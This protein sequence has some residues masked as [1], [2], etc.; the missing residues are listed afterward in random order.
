M[1]LSH[2]LRRLDGEALRAMADAFECGC[3]FMGIARVQRGNRNVTICSSGNFPADDLEGAIS[4]MH[5][6]ARK[7]V[8][9]RL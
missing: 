2:S 8:T 9:P 3:W 4:Q 6:L 1:S 7:Q 5:E